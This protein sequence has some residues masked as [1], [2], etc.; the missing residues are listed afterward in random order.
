MHANIAIIGGSGIY[1]TNMLDKVQEIDVDT[2]F[3]KPSDT[4]IIG[5]YGEKKICFLSRHGAG[6][7]YSPTEVPYRAN[8]FALKKLGVTHI[9]SASAVASLKEE[10]APLDIVIPDQIYDKTHLR[11]NTF[12]EDGIAAHICFDDP[13]CPQTSNLLADIS[14]SR[15]YNVKNKGTYLCI[16]GPHFSTRAESRVHQQLGFDII[17]MSAVPEA[18]LAREAEICYST[19]AT[20]TEYDAWK[21][22]NVS[23]KQV[24]KNAIINETAVKDIISASIEKISLER[25]CKCGSALASA[26]TTSYNHVDKNTLRRLSP[27]ITKYLH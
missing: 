24:I 17:G 2:P 25:D 19:I 7:F 15:G 26:I 20:V 23:I 6:H 12:F 13:F 22:E 27:L 4:I 18:K 21:D 16:E 11:K 10:Y 1:D 5:E 3:G 9:I 14:R 8:I